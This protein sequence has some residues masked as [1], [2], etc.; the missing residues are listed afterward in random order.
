MVVQVLTPG[1]Q[2]HQHANRRTQPLGIGGHVAQRGG[3][4]AHEQVVDNGGIGEGEV[5]EFRRQRE[6]HMMVFDRQQVL[7]LLIEPVGSSQGLALGTVAVAA[8]VVGDALVAAIET[9]LD[10]AAQL[11]RATSGQVTQRL[12]LR[13]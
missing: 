8:R 3:G 11:G 10:V 4:A 7:R 5:A 6:H 9:M 12:A 2:H 1:V 13:A